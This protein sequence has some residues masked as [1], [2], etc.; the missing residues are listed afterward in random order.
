MAGHKGNVE[1]FP[2][3]AW[4]RA[5]LAMV[6]GGAASTLNRKNV[7]SSLAALYNGQSVD[8][9]YDAE[10]RRSNEPHNRDTECGS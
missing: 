1:S 7:C 10:S 2:R 9:R 8:H 3:F 5:D 6:Y 4:N